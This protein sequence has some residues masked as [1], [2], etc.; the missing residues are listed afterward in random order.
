MLTLDNTAYRTTS[1]GEVTFKYLP[2]QLSMVVYWTAMVLTGNGE[3]GFDSGEGA[4]ETAT[5]S[6]DSSRR[7][8][9]PLFIERDSDEK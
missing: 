3:S 2:Y 1:V 6:K 5:M 9:Y 8:T 4:L 7:A